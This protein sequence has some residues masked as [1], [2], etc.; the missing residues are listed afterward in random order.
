MKICRRSRVF[1]G[2]H[3]IQGLIRWWSSKWLSAKIRS[4][5]RSRMECGRDDADPT[6]EFAIDPAHLPSPLKL[7]GGKSKTGEYQY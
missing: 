1:P 7:I 5:W 3:L 4:A 6:L 2:W